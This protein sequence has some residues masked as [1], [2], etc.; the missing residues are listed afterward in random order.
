MLSLPRLFFYKNNFTLF[1]SFFIF[2]RIFVT[3]GKTDGPFPKVLFSSY[4]TFLFFENFIP[5][6]A[7]PNLSS[8]TLFFI[9]SYSLDVLIYISE[10]IEAIRW[11]LSQISTISSVNHPTCSPIFSFPLI[12]EVVSFCQRKVSLSVIWIPFISASIL[13]FLVSFTTPCQLEAF[14]WYFSSLLLKEVKPSLD[15]FPF[16]A[17]MSLHSYLP[18]A[19][20]KIELHVVQFQGYFSVQ[21]T[22]ICY[23]LLHCLPFLSFCVCERDTN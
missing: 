16:L 5:S 12:M 8:P 14:H 1:G 6:F 22:L 9:P 20:V 15:R 3:K 18:C 19:N 7:S 4:V 23:H 17:T 13:L 10:E 21:F 11:E 2:I